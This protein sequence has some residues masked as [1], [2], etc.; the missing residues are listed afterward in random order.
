MTEYAKHRRNDDHWYSPPFYTGPGGY[1]LCIRVA[2]N[3]QG[4]GAGTHV[5][6]FVHLMR[7][8]YDDRLVWSFRGDITI[9]LVNQ[10]SDQEH[11]ERTFNFD[12]F[13]FSQ[14]EE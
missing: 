6:V 14:L 8:E 10:K 3:G 1:K 12:N 11:F 9:Q 13:V 7:G 5:S 4:A 2:A